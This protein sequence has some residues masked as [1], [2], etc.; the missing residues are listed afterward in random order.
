MY[1]AG[2]LCEHPAAGAA[3]A[4]AAVELGFAVREGRPALARL[5]QKAPLRA[6]FPRA[7]AGDLPLAALCNVGGGLV[8]GDRLAI[9]VRVE[10]GAGAL[11]TSQAA[12]KVYR[13]TGP[14]TEVDTRLTV[15]EDAWLE[16]CP[17]ETILFDQARLRRALSLDV[18]AAGRAM[19]GEMLVLGRLASGEQARRGLLHERI[20]VRRAG[21]LLWRDAIRL[22]GDYEPVIDAPAGLGGAR[23]VATF[24]H[25][26]PDAAA[27]LDLARD[28]LGRDAVR[29]GAT[30]VNGLLVARFL[31]HDPLALRTG[32][33]SF[34]SRFRHAVAGLP[35]AMPRLWHV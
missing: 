4:T 31:A 26:A 33:A 22:A 35:P 16:W 2:L 17:Q 23:A 9:G 14:T 28:L 18:A 1:D 10:A 5:W 27:R 24:V 20:E 25:A 29:C 13:S 19:L 21:K 34:W 11:V 15:G 30:L 12:E 3:P 6:L 7:A 8:A 32:F